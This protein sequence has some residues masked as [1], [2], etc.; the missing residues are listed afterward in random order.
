MNIKKKKS[1]CCVK[2]RKSGRHIQPL[3]WDHRARREIQ[4]ENCFWCAGGKA[5]SISCV[6]EGKTEEGFCCLVAIEPP[7]AHRGPAARPAGPPLAFMIARS[8]KKRN[9]LHL[10]NLVKSDLLHS[11]SAS[12]TLH[13]PAT[14]VLK[15]FLKGLTHA[16]PPGSP[17]PPPPCVCATNEELYWT[18]IMKKLLVK[19][20]LPD[21]L[22]PNFSSS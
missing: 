21:T 15:H 12:K 14:S 19:L 13:A 22:L 4:R 3:A 9:K 7:S 20:G 10:C 16:P 11:P 8:F 2:P 6:Q 18:A 1:Q 5:S 17:P